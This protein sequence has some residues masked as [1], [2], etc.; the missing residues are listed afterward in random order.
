WRFAAIAVAAAL[1]LV[2]VIWIWVEVRQGVTS[3]RWQRLAELEYGFEDPSRFPYSEPWLTVQA[4]PADVES[5]DRHVQKLEDFLAKEGSDAAIAA[6][7][8]ALI[9]DLEL[10]QLL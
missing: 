7:V 1:L 8:H 5:R 3:D 6:H 9:A 2:G 4:S 10:T